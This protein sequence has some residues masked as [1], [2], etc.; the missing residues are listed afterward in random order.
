MNTQGSHVMGTEGSNVGGKDTINENDQIVYQAF[1][2]CP[3][4]TIDVRSSVS[5]LISLGVDIGRPLDNM[6]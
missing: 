3:Y 4:Y 5:D 6:F 2:W 1:G